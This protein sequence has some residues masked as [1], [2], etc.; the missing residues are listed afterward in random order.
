MRL[1]FTL[2]VLLCMD[3][4]VLAD[5]LFNE[6]GFRINN[7][8][9]ATPESSPAGQILSTQ[10]LRR[11]I[12]S[13]SPVLIDVQAITLRPESTEFGHAWL[14]SRTRWHIDGSTWL[15]NIGYGELDQRMQSYFQSNLQRLTQGNKH[16]A[17]VFYCVVDCWMSWNAVRRAAKW[18]Y[19]NIFWYP[20]GTDG[21]EQAGLPLVEAAPYPLTSKEQQQTTEDGFFSPYE[22]LDLAQVAR[23]AKHLDKEILL[24]F[25]TEHCPY[26]TRMNRTVLIDPGVIDAVR[27]HFIALPVNIESDADMRDEH[28]QSMTLREFSGKRFRIVRTPTLVFVDAKFDLLHKHSGLVATPG[29]MKIL[30]QFVRTRAYDS[31]PWQNY[32]RQSH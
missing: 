11:L 3:G 6:Q 20:D 10:Q 22:V 4:A 19:S 1:L 31:Q 25:E 13:E 9:R 32:K 18:G 27:S 28:G 5:T 12:Q 8:R 7:Y 14:P 15:P 29:E 23:Q 17:I 24:F 16:R 2:L 21:W 30:L 26:C